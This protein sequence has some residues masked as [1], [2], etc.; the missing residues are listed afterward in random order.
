MNKKTLRI[1]LAGSPNV[2]KSTI[3]NA[4]TGGNAYVGNWP[5]VTVERKDGIFKYKDYEITITDLPGT[6]SLTPLSIDERIVRD[7]LFKEK[8]D[9]VVCVVDSTNLLRSLY[10]PL[11]LRELGANVVIVFNMWDLVEGKLE[12]N[13]K[14]ME[15]V[16][17]ASI[18]LTSG[19]KGTGIEELKEKIVEAKDRQNLPLRVDYGEE[20]ERY[21]KEIEFEL[22]DMAFPYE[23]RFL[24]IKLLEGDHIFKENLKSTGYGRVVEIAKRGTEEFKNKSGRDLETTIIERRYGYIEA[25]VKKYTKKITLLEERFLLSDKIDKILVNKYLGI[26]IFALFMWLTFELTFRIGGF[27]SDYIDLFFGWLGDITTNY[28]SSI[29]SPEL[30]ISFIKDG[31]IGGLGSILVFL[32]NIM[33]LFFI[34]SFLEDVGYMSRAAFIMDEFMRSIGLSGR[35]FIPMILG[36]GCNVP[37]IMATRTIPEERERILTILIN[38]FMSCSARFPIY[39]LFAGVFFERNQGLIVF[40]LY[41]LGI[42]I[43]ILSVL[44]FTKFLPSLRGEVSPLIM[45]IPPYRLPTIRGLWIPTWERTKEFLKKAGTIIFLGVVLIWLL[46]SIPPSS[47]YGS[48]NTIIGMIGKVLAPILGPAGFP[49]WQVAVA[50]IFGVVAKETVVST[51]GTLLGGEENL[52]KSLL[53]LFTPLSAYS[54]MIMT[55]FYTPCLAT[56]GAIRK[57]TNWKWALFSLFYSLLIGWTMSVL[58]YQVGSLFTK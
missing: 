34:L 37:A 24:A 30:L 28:L 8:P 51:L 16:L 57:E 55:L 29:N 42:V 48:E 17:G 35:S 5:G 19:T 50:L 40:S 6:Y 46:A 9:V 1:G 22:K 11:L 18:V 2:G 20:I 13:K 58:F 38:P 26:P 33:V 4:L 36:F 39:V 31:I 27:F 49:Y 43:A 14:E 3:F 53:G 56:I 15:K 52:S 21:I 41:T 44:I 23:R 7:F 54:F 25:V 12:I 10:L 32:P 47:E 45:E